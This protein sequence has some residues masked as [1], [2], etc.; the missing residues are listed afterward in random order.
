MRHQ[1]IRWTYAEL[2]GEV[3][4][5]ARALM[6]AGLEPGDRMG[7]WAP[8]CAEWVLAQYA[9][10]KAGVILVNVNP[11]YRTSEL[12]FVLNQ[13]GCRMLV[14]ARSFKTSDYVAMVERGPAVVPALE[15]VVFL[16]SPDWDALRRAR[17]GGR[18]RGAAR[19]RG[20]AAVRRPDQPPVHERHDGL[21][22]GRHALAPQHP[23]QRL[24]RRRGL[25]LHARRTGSA[26]PCPSTTASAWS[27]ATWAAPRTARAWS[28]RRRRSSPAR[29]SRRSRRSAARRSTACRRCSS[30]SSTTPEFGDYD[31]SSLR[32]GIMAGSPCP[33]EVMRKVLDRMHMA[34]GDHLLRHD[35][36]LAGVHADGRRRRRRAPHRHRRPR[37]SA[38][39]DQGRRPG[40]RRVRP[41]RRA[42]R[43]VHARL[44]R[45]ARLL[46]RAGED[47]RGDRPRRL[48][49][50]RRP[51]HDGRATAT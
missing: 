23:Q 13:S 6:A 45:D 27:W 34:R 39:R 41:A 25:R 20:R 29:R 37:P 4:R 38:R 32:T 7:I 10:A 9:S 44:L 8:N 21:P 11:A 3:D 36:D 22:Q 42:R 16:D 33:V 40:E 14:A 28:S 35:G 5:V 2:D 47:G 17:G 51:R 18:A 50:H 15:Q 19:A 48:D 26:S 30:R 49:A 12:A 24:L 1:G 46:G 43:A 31:L